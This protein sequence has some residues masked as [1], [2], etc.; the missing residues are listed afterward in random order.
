M[1]PSRCRFRLLL[2]NLPLA[3]VKPDPLSGAVPK[4]AHIDGVRFHRQHATAFARRLPRAPSL[5]QLFDCLKEFVSAKTKTCSHGKQM[6]E[7]ES[8][9]VK[10][11]L[12]WKG[13]WLTES[14]VQD[15]CLETTL[16]YA[17]A[18][19]AASPGVVPV[20]ED[21]TRASGQA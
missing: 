17:S 20:G 6:P 16:E 12:K 10:C 14:E 2:G 9:R 11:A 7:Q 15:V 5:S 4:S 1:G 13:F 8:H 3:R 19:L 21:G 18:V